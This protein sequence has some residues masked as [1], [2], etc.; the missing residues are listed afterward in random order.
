[1]RK[2]MLFVISAP[3]G[4]G[5]S[6]VVARVRERV[7]GLEFSVSCTT[8]ARRGAERDGVEYRFIGRGDFERMIGA[9][10][11]VEWA[12]VH[13][14][15]YGTPRGPIEA[16]IAGGKDV[17]L[18]IDVQGGMAI[19]RIFP[20]AVTVFILPPGGGELEARLRGRGTES[21][22]QIRLRLENARRELGFASRY[23]HRIVNDDVERA[24][25]ELAAL[26]E[27]IRAGKTS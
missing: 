21:P 25:A 15:L 19:K 26:I 22:E 10:E 4:A 16:A 18:D 8:R 23:D 1:M 6:T 14:E 3:S 20:D 11:F 9:G 5:K 7:P 24:A 27:G 13:G 2:G 12:E 17:L